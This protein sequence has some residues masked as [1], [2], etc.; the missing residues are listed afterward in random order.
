MIIKEISIYFNRQFAVANDICEINLMGSN[1]LLLS[2]LQPSDRIAYNAV[3]F[4]FV[5]TV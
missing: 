1:V 3:L 2:R 5:V 4:A